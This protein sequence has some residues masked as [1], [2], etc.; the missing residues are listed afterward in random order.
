MGEGAYRNS[1]A[2]FF[3]SLMREP[4]EELVE[5]VEVLVTEGV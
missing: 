4:A 1:L 3:A 5:L 2:A